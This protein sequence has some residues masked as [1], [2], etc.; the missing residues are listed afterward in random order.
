MSTDTQTRPLT[1]REQAVADVQRF[2]EDARRWQAQ[3]ESV[4]AELARLSA[5][6]AESLLDDPDPEAGQR[7]SSRLLT[8]REQA[9]VAQRTAE[10]ARTRCGRAR[11]AVAA[12]EAGELEQPL[13]AAREA[14]VAHDTRAGE[15]LQALE[16]FT[17]A[18]YREVTMD[19]LAYELEQA[20]GTSVGL[21]FTP[22]KRHTL[23]AE[24]AQCE[25]RRQAALAAARGDNAFGAVPGLAFE[26]LPESL[27]PGGVLDL[28]M[29]DPVTA[30]AQA[31]EAL[32]G[33]VAES[34][35][36]MQQAQEALDALRDRQVQFP[37]TDLH[38]A[39]RTAERALEKATER[40]Y[41]A[42]G[43]AGLP[44]MAQMAS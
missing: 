37:H 30:A 12:A 27:G 10:A 24:V 7:L 14:L 13:A 40:C 4:A 8:L 43:R 2:D 32:Q 41:T 18:R 19:M 44:V 39:V 29:V 17:G 5:G 36:A 31:E 22:P 1:T 20:K 21:R 42:R 9:E 15:L 25:R 16:D 28:G 23:Q 6:A 34:E 35:Q 33:E 3:A 38:D 26:D 11:R